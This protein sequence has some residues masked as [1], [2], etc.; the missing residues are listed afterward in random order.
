[1]SKGSRVFLIGIIC[2]LFVTIIALLSWTTTA[3]ATINSDGE[4][5]VLKQTVIGQLDGVYGTCFVVK[6]D[7]TDALYLCTTRY[8]DLVP[9]IDGDGS[10]VTYQEFLE[11]V[12]MR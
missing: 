1:M 6:L 11:R 8:N 10:P 2:A 12:E 9:Y 7:C 4:L 3:N 5:I